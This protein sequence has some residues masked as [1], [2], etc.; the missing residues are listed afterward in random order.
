M[1]SNRSRYNVGGMPAPPLGRTLGAVAVQRNIF[2]RLLVG[3]TRSAPAGTRI[4][5]QPTF[6]SSGPAPVVY[7]GG[8]SALFVDEARGRIQLLQTEAGMRRGPTNGGPRRD[9]S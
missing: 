8:V 4:I 3:L 7:A 6:R 2:R 1:A 5:A 9:T